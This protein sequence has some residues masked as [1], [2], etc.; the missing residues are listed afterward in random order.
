MRTERKHE[1]RIRKPKDKG[2]KKKMLMKMILGKN[3]R[4][5]EI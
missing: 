1:R 3:I 4:R 2:R 5:K